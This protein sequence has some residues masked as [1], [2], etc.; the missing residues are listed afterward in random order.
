L[1]SAHTHK[2]LQNEDIDPH[3]GLWFIGAVR[4]KVPVESV[5]LILIVLWFWKEGVRYGAAVR[6]AFYGDPGGLPPAL[7]LFPHP[8]PTAVVL[9]NGALSDEIRTFGHAVCGGSVGS[10]ESSAHD[11]LHCGWANFL[12]GVFGGRLFLCDGF[13][14]R[15]G[16]RI[17]GGSGAGTKR[18]GR[19]EAEAGQ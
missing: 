4:G 11:F 17:Y 18:Q 7:A 2:S 12:L 15:R 14:H 5:L 6:S 16:G 1:G 19:S 13:G 8:S 3:I 10:G 9:H